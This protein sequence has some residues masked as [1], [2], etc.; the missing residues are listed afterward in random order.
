MNLNDALTSL[1]GLT[2]SNRP[3]RLKLW[4][5]QGIVED[6]L[7]VKQVSGIEA[8]FGGIE[9]RLLCV[10]AKAGLELKQFI[11]MPAEVQFV[12]S[13][14]GLRS[15]C[16][17]V[18]VAEEGESDGGLATYQLIV[19][20]A[21]SIMDKG[22]NTRIFSRMN[23]VDITNLVLADWC[24]ANPV[25]GR[26][27]NFEI[28][29]LKTSYPQREF[30]M[31]YK[32]SDTAFLRRL[33]KRRG[34]AWFFQP[35]AK[36]GVKDAP[37][38]TLVLFD[39][40]A[41]LEQNSAGI[42]RYHRDDGTEVADSITAW[43]GVRTLVPGSVTRQ[44][45]D[46]KNVQMSHV[47]ISGCTD[48][49]VLGNQ[50]AAGLDDGLIDVQH[51]GDSSADYRALGT[52]RM[53]HHEFIAKC[54]R[55]EGGG[56]EWS[57]GQWSSITGHAEIDSHPASERDFVFIEL[58]V[59]AENNLSK[60]LGDR[61]KR[62][63]ALNRWSTDED[64]S[65]GA[66]AGLARAS[67]ERDGRYTV[68]F[69]CVRRG[70]PIAP[71]YDPRID[72][73]RTGE[74]T[75]MVIGPEGESVHCDELGRVRVRFPG[76][77][78]EEHE[79]VRAVAAGVTA[80]DSAWVLVSTG[81]AGAGF[82]VIS[83]PRVG[84]FCQ[85]G[86]MGGDPDKPIITG[87]THSGATPPPCFSGVSVLPGDRYLSGI[88]SRE[89]GGTRANQL[90]IDDTAGQI[91]VQLA[92]GH[93]STQLNL[94]YLTHPRSNGKAKPRGDGFE[95]TT[96]ENGS[97]RTA[98]ALLISTWARLN[99]CAN[100]GGAEEHHALMRECAELF[101]SLGDVAFANQA[102]E[103][104]SAPQAE[105]KDDIKAAAAGGNTDP[106]GQGGK[107]TLSLTAPAGIAFT[108]PKTILSYAGMNIDT[109]AQQHVQITSGQRFNINAGKGISMFAHHDGIK[110]IAYYGKFVMQSQH[111]DTEIN[112]AK[113]IKVTATDGI[114]SVMAKEILLIAEDGSFIKIGGGITLGTNGDI[115]NQ[116]ANFPFSGPATMHAEMP[117]FNGATP[118][119]KFI[120]KYG[121]HTEAAII[122][123]NRGYEIDMSDGSTVKGIADAAGNTSLLARDAMHIANVRILTDKK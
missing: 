84:T 41:S 88:V 5:N 69:T 98:K 7:L 117:A 81:W 48:Q 30:T 102:L 80:H 38:H 118:D 25:L 119:Q 86:F 106:E 116:A 27:F 115:K 55:G 99:A 2:G 120:L 74:E 29:R 3:I 35:T 40:V 111:D 62:L 57:P 8:V 12:T 50:F 26:A 32:E 122:A 77:R 89:I 22:C 18:D 107:P 64:A 36:R 72:L 49:G 42:V 45:W 109:V 1:S 92:S 15:V 61:I 103:L 17:I 37:S 96:N 66:E 13:T 123:P 76:V 46:Y 10:A 63:F 110:Q 105:L 16:G 28:W 19:R 75:V 100:Q 58:R 6:L 82:G 71:L 4:S 34:I 9:Y 24:R 83:L 85:V 113:N 52:L 95:L 78:P 60:T 20:D 121:Q 54:C 91:S 101:K 108:T 114:A 21:L 94:G 79:G 87:A 31:Q 67:A 97:I 70:I 11:A 104:D 33:W 39:D 56:R 93:A 53:L 43:H 65:G 112:S 90:R 68:Q 59:A 23:E 47:S 73:P 14:G 51:A 44:S